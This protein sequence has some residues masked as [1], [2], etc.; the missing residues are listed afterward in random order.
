MVLEIRNDGANKK[1][2]GW[3]QQPRTIISPMGSD[4]RIGVEL[5]FGD[6]QNPFPEAT[7]ALLESLR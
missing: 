1:R 6:Q 7:N 2:L 5:S 3:H 4:L